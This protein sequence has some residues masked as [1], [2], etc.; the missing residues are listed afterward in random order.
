MSARLQTTMI[1]LA[2][3]LAG[4]LAADSAAAPARLTPRLARALDATAVK[5]D[6]SLAVWVNF[7]GRDLT[8][9]ALAAALQEAESQ[10]PPRL[11]ERRLKL[12]NTNSLN[13]NDETKLW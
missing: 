1:A 12:A 2:L 5:A 6:E 10:L 13:E 11:R 3:L 8:G 7:T 9:A 4:A